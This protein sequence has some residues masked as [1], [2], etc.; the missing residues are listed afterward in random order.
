MK[1]PAILALALAGCL[2]LAIVETTI[3]IMPFT[4]WGVFLDIMSVIVAF[5]FG[6]MA[7]F[8]SNKFMVQERL[9]GLGKH[10]FGSWAEMEK[11][12]ND[13]PGWKMEQLIRNDFV[14]WNPEE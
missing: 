6:D 2:F 4:A 13:T 12:V 3:R 1:V 14:D 8:F 9:W 10:K 11:F 5:F 7:A